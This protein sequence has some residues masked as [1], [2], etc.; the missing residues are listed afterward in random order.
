MLEAIKK[1]WARY[2]PL[3]GLIAL[4]GHNYGEKI[5]DY[6]LKVAI[7]MLVA[8][9]ALILPIS[10]LLPDKRLLLKYHGTK[11]YLE[12]INHGIS[13]FDMALGVY[14]YRITN[15]LFGL[16][17]EGM[18][19]V[20]IGSWEGDYSML[21]AHWMHDRGKILAFEPEPDNCT[22][23]RRNIQINNYKCINLYEC[24]LSD[25]EETAAFYPGTGVGSLVFRPWWNTGLPITVKT[26]TLDNILNQAHIDKVDLIKIDV[27]GSELSVLKGAER[28]LRN[29]SIP[30]I[31]DVDVVSD[32][33]RTELYELLT[34]FGYEMYR[35]GKHLTR[36]ESADSLFL[37]SD[38][39]IANT[40]NS[41]FNIDA[42]LSAFEKCIRRI[43][44]AKLRPTIGSIYY[45]IRP[46]F[47][48]RTTV[49]QV[50]AIKKMPAQRP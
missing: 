14:E 12:L 29:N 48:P 45:S 8:R 30:L 25:K 35:I 50:Y 22:W 46:Q 23:F 9:L 32:A 17:K 49:R 1:R 11:I 42:K 41:R 40:P 28:T 36:I 10:I 3:F 7:K 24:A 2:N 18:T 5:R 4:R 26:Q 13:P 6:P 43:I 44:P 34:S 38:H 47:G 27:E 15:L 39:V 20:D 19:I 37:S 33:E 31:M 16:V 21:F